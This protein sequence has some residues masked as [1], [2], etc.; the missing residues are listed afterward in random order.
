MVHW[1]IEEG[2][3]LAQIAQ[4][5]RCSTRTVAR[6]LKLYYIYQAVDN[7]LLL[8]EQ[9]RRFTPRIL[10]V[11]DMEWLVRLYDAQPS[12]YLDEVVDR[13]ATD[14]DIKVSIST[15]C[16][17]LINYGITSKK[18]SK[19]ALERNEL[20]RAAFVAHIS[21]YRPD[22]IVAIDE[23]GMEDRHSRC[24]RGRARHRAASNKLFA[25]GKRLSFLPALT[26]TGIQ[27]LVCWEGG[28]KAQTVLDFV[29][30]KNPHSHISCTQDP[31]NVRLQ[32]GSSSFSTRSSTSF[33]EWE[34]GEQVHRCQHVC[35][36]MSWSEETCKR[37]GKFLGTG[38]GEGRGRM[39]GGRRD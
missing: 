12:L 30:K 19:R 3:S 37:E 27:A 11:D 34:E 38:D 2:L 17:N 26:V 14:C 1:R 6:I 33:T 32:A 20:R 5:L 9:T 8:P 15:L 18:L 36:A 39:S 28:G 23:S 22:Q 4:R 35:F 31:T 16:R 21:Q 13:L 25:G 24:S 7:P 29:K 10:M